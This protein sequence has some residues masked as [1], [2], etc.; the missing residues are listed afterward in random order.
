MR[1]T[2]FFVIR[3]L[4]NLTCYLPSPLLILG[5]MP[6]KGE[7]R[8]RRSG[9]VSAHNPVIGWCW[10]MM[11]AE[12]EGISPSLKNDIT[13]PRWEDRRDLVPESGTKKER[14]KRW[15]PA[16]YECQPWSGSRVKCWKT[17][18][19]WLEYRNGGSVGKLCHIS[20]LTLHVERQQ[21]K[22]RSGTR[23]GEIRSEWEMRNDKIKKAATTATTNISGTEQAGESH[24]F[25]LTI[26]DTFAI[27]ICQVHFELPIT[28]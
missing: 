27:A 26:N 5:K 15:N 14:K 6:L 2:H 28:N 1:R 4:S 23:V 24:A 9:W 7:R 18:I 13:L 3:E 11:A 8:V 25:S 19:R 16:H 20:E 22:L 21:R 17:L 10:W 12:K